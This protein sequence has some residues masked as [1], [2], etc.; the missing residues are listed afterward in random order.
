MIRHAVSEVLKTEQFSSVIP[1]EVEKVFNLESLCS[2]FKNIHMPATIGDINRA[3]SRIALENLV[4]IVHASKNAVKIGRNVRVGTYKNLDALFAEYKTLLPFDLTPSQ[5]KAI[6]EIICD[7]ES[8]LSMNRLLEGDVGS[9][10]T[11]V[12]TFLLYVAAKNN[13]QAVLMAPTEILARQ[14]FEFISRVFEGEFGIN[15]VYLSSSMPASEKKRNLGYIKYGMANIIIGSHSVFSKSVEYNNLGAVIIDEQHKFGVKARAM[16]QNKGR[17][18]DTLT[19]SATP[20]PR[21]LALSFE[22][23]L[24]IS[25]LNARPNALSVT[26]NIVSQ[27]KSDD[28]WNYLNS[29][30]KSGSKVFV[31]CPKIE[32]GE[33][34]G[35]QENV[36]R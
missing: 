11:A 34:D 21:S 17:N 19:M 31:V 32:S 2:S 18:A 30:I 7:L 10:K 29:K 1:M 24:D 9:G 3:K 5:N 23:C 28:M 4:P 14:H 35:I 26:T 36:R 16:L 12:A 20:I 27:S 8:G 25:I 15:V 33:D 13:M 6:E 22:G